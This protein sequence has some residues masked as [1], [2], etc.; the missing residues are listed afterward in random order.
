MKQGALGKTV[1]FLVLVSL[2]VFCMSCDQEPL[3]YDIATGYPPIEPLIGGAPSKIVEYPSGSETLYITN[4]II[5]KY[6]SGSWTRMSNQPPVRT[7]DIAA[8]NGSPETLYALGVDGR[9]YSST[10]GAWVG[11]IAVYEKI[12]S[13]F[14]AGSAL[15]AC[16]L[17]GTPGTNNGYTIYINGGSP[18]SNTGKLMGAVV[19]SSTTYLGTLGAGLFTAAAPSTLIQETV[20]GKEIIGLATDNSDLFIATPS[21]VHCLSGDVTL[22]SYA[23]SGGITVWDDGSNQL[24]LA[25]IRRSNSAFRYGYREIMFSSSQ[26]P[27]EPGNTVNTVTSVQKDSTYSAIGKHVVNH[28]YVVNNSSANNGGYPIIFASTA[29]DGLWSY[30]IRSNDKPPE[31]NGER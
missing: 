5:S 20:I 10:G 23:Y 4:G 13:I 22:D 18:I 28:L 25:G 1:F 14:G 21:K 9:I 12:E 30:K 11:P 17:T 7:R 31:W 2:C 16:R 8:V 26:R 3:F 29:K 15:Y 19:V 27:Q 6:D 24:L